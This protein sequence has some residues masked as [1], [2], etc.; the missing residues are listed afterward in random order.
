MLAQ[1]DLQGLRQELW[2]DPTDT[3]LVT[4]DDRNAAQKLFREAAA[5]L[6]KG[7]AI[8]PTIAEAHNGLGVTYAEL[9]DDKTA[10]ESYSSAIRIKPQYKSAYENRAKAYARIGEAAKSAADVATAA[11]LPDQPKLG[12]GR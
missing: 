4:E 10:I 1:R 9:G 6:K 12:V 2:V 11:S 8:D 5:D 3:R 7:V